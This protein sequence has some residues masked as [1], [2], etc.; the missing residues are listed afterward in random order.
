MTLVKETAIKTENFLLADQT[1]TKILALQTQLSKMDHQL[2]ADI[3][4]HAITAW[5]SGIADS[6]SGY[7]TNL[8]GFRK[9]TFLFRFFYLFLI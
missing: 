2:N 4:I 7:L 8:A 5:L 1:R 3:T 9:V 6:I